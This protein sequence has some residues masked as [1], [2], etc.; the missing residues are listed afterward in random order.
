MLSGVYY[1]ILFRLMCSLPTRYDKLNLTLI[2]RPI[3][4]L[5]VIKE[6]VPIDVNCPEL[7]SVGV[8][9]LYCNYFDIQ[10]YLRVVNEDVSH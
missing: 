7:L 8:Q 2:N 6:V 5:L 9:N 3:S 4:K 1:K 10:T